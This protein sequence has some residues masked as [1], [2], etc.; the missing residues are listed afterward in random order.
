MQHTLTHAL[1]KYLYKFLI[2]FTGFLFKFFSF[3]CLVIYCWMIGMCY[4]KCYVNVNQILVTAKS[5]S[6][7]RHQTHAT[8]K[9][10][11]IWQLLINHWKMALLCIF[12]QPRNALEA[13]TKHVKQPQRYSKKIAGT[14]AA[15]QSLLFVLASRSNM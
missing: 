9:C 6:G 2:C 14:P 1:R 10:N 8:L 11:C 4:E 7:S 13:E 5:Q 15:T 3:F 12:S